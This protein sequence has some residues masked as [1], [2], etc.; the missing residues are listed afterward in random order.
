MVREPQRTHSEQEMY[1]KLPTLYG[2]LDGESDPIDLRVTLKPTRKQWNGSPIWNELK[3]G[4]DG[5]ALCDQLP[6]LCPTTRRIPSAFRHD[7]F[8]YCL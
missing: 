1:G 2:D 6:N 7:I 8:K 4:R 5:G 3:N